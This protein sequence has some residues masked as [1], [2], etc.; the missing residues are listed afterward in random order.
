MENPVADLMCDG[1][2]F[3]PDSCIEPLIAMM[4]PLPIEDLRRAPSQPVSSISRTER[5]NFSATAVRSATS[6]QSD[7]SGL[8]PR[9]AFDVDVRLLHRLE[10]LLGSEMWNKLHPRSVAFIL[11]ME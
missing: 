5:F 8:V 10:L 6:F 9:W 4:P 2:L 1:E 3:L 7:D 11:L